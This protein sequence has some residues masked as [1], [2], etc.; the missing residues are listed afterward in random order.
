LTVLASDLP[1]NDNGHIE[2]HGMAE[3]MHLPFWLKSLNIL[4]SWSLTVHLVKRIHLLENILI[5]RA[6]FRR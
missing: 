3:C 6:I 5:K 4:L 2:N 1:M